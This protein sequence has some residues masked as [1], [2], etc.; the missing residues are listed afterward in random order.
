MN[1]AAP[2]SGSPALSIVAGAAAAVLGA[3][4]WGVV[5]AATHW[6]VGLLAV[7][8]GVAVGFAMSRYATS[9]RVL[10][11][12]AAVLALAGC[13]LGDLISDIIAQARFEEVP[14][15]DAFRIT[16]GDPTLAWDLFSGY[17]SVMNL[18][19]IHI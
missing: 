4:T 10:I 13:V 11:P 15:A 17:F 2:R 14:L 8:I 18:S 7:G 9:S 19:L 6:Q 12:V 16:A 3:V 5:V 1:G